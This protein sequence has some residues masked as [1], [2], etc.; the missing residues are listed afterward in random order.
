MKKSNDDSRA[1][2][3]Q[4]ERLRASLLKVELISRGSV[5]DRTGRTSG[6]GYQWT[7]KLAGKTVTV[8]LT[9]EQFKKMKEAVAQY[10]A[11]QKILAQME[12]LSRRMIFE[13][14]PHP[15][16]R[17]TLSKKVLGLI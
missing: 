1:L 10:R 16:R 7:R 14:S 9:P 17:K 4:F 11:L 13:G 5:Q 6:R 3:K 2:Q 15:S 12:K 8:A